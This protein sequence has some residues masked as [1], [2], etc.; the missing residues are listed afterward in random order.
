MQA[1]L[2]LFS[3]GHGHV[4]VRLRFCAR[5]RQALPEE[6]HSHAALHEEEE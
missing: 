5:E 6:E 4:Y 1:L 3:A 2:Q